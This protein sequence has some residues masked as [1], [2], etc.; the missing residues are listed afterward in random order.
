M[1]T[2]V[3]LPG[4]QARMSAS[5]RFL[6]LTAATCFNCSRAFCVNSSFVLHTIENSS[7]TLSRC[8]TTITFNAFAAIASG[9]C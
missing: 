8:S 9:G 3:A 2:G 6:A 7:E 4:N 1:L 5:E